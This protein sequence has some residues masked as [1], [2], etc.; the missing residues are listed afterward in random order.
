MRIYS[1]FLGS[2]CLIVLELK[3][4]KYFW[5]N[6]CTNKTNVNVENEPNT[7]RLFEENVGA[8]FAEVEHHPFLPRR[9]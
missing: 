4:K 2:M 6:F 7:K 8:N 5:E 1:S 3:F 9:R